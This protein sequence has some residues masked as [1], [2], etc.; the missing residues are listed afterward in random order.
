MNTVEE[1]NK[2]C[3]ERIESQMQG[4]FKDLENLDNL[5]EMEEEEKN[6]VLLDFGYEGQT[7]QDDDL[8]DLRS[9]LINEYPL[10]VSKLELIRIELSTGGPGDYIEIQV[11]PENKIVVSGKYYFIDWFDSAYRVLSSEQLDLIE[12]LYGYLWD[13]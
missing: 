13:N 8:D 5:T 6:K 7:Y 3:E 11:D 12:R 2:K 1:R 9:D 10:A 4:R